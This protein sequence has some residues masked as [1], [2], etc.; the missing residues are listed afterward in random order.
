[1]V[2]GRHFGEIDNLRYP[3]NGLTDLDKIWHDDAYWTP[4]PQ[5]P[6]AFRVYEDQHGRRPLL[7]VVCISV[8]VGRRMAGLFL[9][10]QSDE[11]C[12]K[13]ATSSCQTTS[14]LV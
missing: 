11:G 13:K 5:W 9:V 7:E 12:F 1:M 6:S 14:S 3:R 2:D 10:H 8:K 4:G